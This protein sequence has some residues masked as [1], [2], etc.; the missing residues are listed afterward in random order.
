MNYCMAGDKRLELSIRLDI[1]EWDNERQEWVSEHS[2]AKVAGVSL[3]MSTEQL[4]ESDLD[5]VGMA[6]ERLHREGTVLLEEVL[7]VVS[8][9]KIHRRFRELVRLWP[10]DRPFPYQVMS[11]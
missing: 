5:L 11:D 4:S 9:D 7:S 1:K 10:V 6:R 2:R 3:A 8:R